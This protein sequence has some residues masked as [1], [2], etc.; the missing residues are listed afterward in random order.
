MRRPAALCQLNSPDRVLCG[1]SATVISV[2]IAAL[3][4]WPAASS[5]Q[6]TT[7][8]PAQPPP[9]GAGQ[10][11]TAEQEN[12]HKEM[13]ATPRRTNGCYTAT[14]PERQWREVPCK[15][16]PHKLYLP[17]MGGITRLDQVGGNGIDFAMVGGG[18]QITQAEGRFD[19]ATVTATPAYSLQ[20]NTDFFPTSTCTGS[21]NPKCKGWEQFVYESGGSGFIEYW[22]I[23]YGP[24]GT[25]CP[26]PRGASCVNGSAF[27]D[28]WCPY[29]DP[30]DTDPNPV[31]CVV[32]ASG[33]ASP[34]ATPATSLDQIRVNGAA[35][36]VS[37]AASDA[38]VVTIGGTDY[39]ASGNNYF[40]DLG[41]QW[42]EA[43][44]NVFGDGGGSQAVFNDKDSAV[45]R[46]EDLSGTN[47]RPRC[48]QRSWT[49]ESSNLT[50]QNVP[51]KA[52]PG[53][54]PALVF[55]QDNPAPTGG[56]ADCTDAV[57]L[58]DTHL[59]TF[60]GL[61]YDFQ[62]SG[63]FLLAEEGPTE[64]GP[65]FVV[66]P[67]QVVQPNFVVQT[68]QASGAPTWPDASVNKAVATR[69][70]ETTVAICLAPTRLLI[71]GDSFTLDDQQSVFLP[72]DIT[73]SRAGDLYIIQRENGDS[74]RARLNQGA[75]PKYDW[76]DVTVY[77]GDRLPNV[78]GLLGNPDGDPNLIGLSDGTVLREPVTFNTL[79]HHYG[80]S[81]RVPPSE[82]LLFCNDQSIEVGDP[83]KPFYAD[84]LTEAQQRSAQ[85]ICT[86]A[87]V[88]QPAALADCILDVTV[89][90][91]PRAAPGH[92]RAPI[93]AAVWQAGSWRG[94]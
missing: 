55:A 88:E 37:G 56:A 9:A 33:A 15:T 10:P 40:P 58:G 6:P 73:L 69:M 60:N 80:E 22:L 3:L 5:A 17:R 41:T 76:I 50:L 25:M 27:S 52:S 46:I 72:D 86:E 81:W 57:S 85:A 20:L 45:V 75:Q 23:R 63:D 8:T 79:Y 36:G 28:G 29:S 91:T 78:R 64:A 84:N 77:F 44:F 35:A 61:H 66:Q 2:L 30:G 71:D 65:N 51:P 90:G 7:P 42:K 18:G 1:H 32:N 31:Y 74:V 59:N 13:L 67:N 12:W 21:P 38:I 68:R 24:A 87:G 70:G 43:E 16:P 14:Y 53:A 26:M 93:P 94:P 19:T 39:S 11:T 4:A 82:S 49:A 62:A 54:F 89:L 83:R 34:P 47:L 48:D 92:A